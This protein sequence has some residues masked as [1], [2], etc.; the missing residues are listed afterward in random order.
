MVQKSRTGKKK[1]N[2]YQGKQV[3][4]PNKPKEDP[5]KAAAKKVN[6]IWMMVA[7][8]YLLG[9]LFAGQ[10]DPAS[11][12]YRVINIICN[13]ALVGVGIFMVASAR[14]FEQKGSSS[15]NKIFGIVL[16]VLGVMQLVTLF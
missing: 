12:P 7:I 3:A 11:M 16:V 6:R 5:N 4:Q 1:R 13:V 2:P 15:M 10:F 14:V 9:I 8:L